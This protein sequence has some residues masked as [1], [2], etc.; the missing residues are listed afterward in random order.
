MLGLLS[1]NLSSGHFK[2]EPSVQCRLALLNCKRRVSGTWACACLDSMR[3]ERVWV[4]VCMCIRVCVH[5]RVGVH[6]VGSCAS[7]E[8]VCMSVGAR[9]GVAI[10]ASTWTPKS[11]PKGLALLN[12]KMSLR[13]LKMLSLWRW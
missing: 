8:A 10:L 7:V 2:T 11:S 3:G 4:G 1:K 5:L 9:A 13:S 6:I 12:V